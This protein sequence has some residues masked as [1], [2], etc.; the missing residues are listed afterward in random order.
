MVGGFNLPLWKIWF[1]QLGWW[2]SQYMEYKMS[3]SPPTRLAYERKH[4]PCTGQ[5]LAEFSAQVLE[6]PPV[7]TISKRPANT[8]ASLDSKRTATNA[9][10]VHH[11]PSK[12]IR[13]DRNKRRYKYIKWLIMLDPTS[14]SSC[15]I[16]HLIFDKFLWS[17]PPIYSRG[18]TATMRRRCKVLMV[19]L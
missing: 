13:D 19:G 6:G 14:I 16:F 15:N 2:H 17:K 3:Q 12:W 11:W 4:R 18:S 1:R 9:W 10:W 8:L 5:F 7:A